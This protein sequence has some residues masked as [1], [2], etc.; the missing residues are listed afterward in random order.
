MTTKPS[1]VRGSIAALL[2]LT[3]CGPA[4][5][6]PAGY[7]EWPHHQGD[8]AASKYAPLDQITPENFE[9]LEVAWRWESADRRL[10]DVYDTGTYVATPLKV[11]NRLY[12]AT[13]HGQVVALDPATGQ[14]LW[15][16]DP[17]SWAEEMPTQLPRHTRG[18]EYWTDGEIERIFVAT[19]GKQLVSI[20]AATGRPDPPSARTASWT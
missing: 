11:G 2:L 3:G 9:Q 12:T 15:L 6:L 19:L 14:Q 17:R 7:G 18:V 8:L 16:H 4:P 20:D 1:P 10:G 5:D 13:S